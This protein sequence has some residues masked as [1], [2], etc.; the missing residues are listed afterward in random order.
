MGS[1]MAKRWQ[2]AGYQVVAY[3]RTAAKAEELASQG[4]VTAV[5]TVAELV[6]ALSAP[7]IVYVMVPAGQAI[8][9][10]LFGPEG[11]ADQ[12][13]A[14]DIVVDAGNSNYLDT[15]RRSKQLA[16]RQIMLVDQGTSGGVLG[17]TAGYCVMIGGEAE[18]VQRV[19]PL[20]RAIAMED[21]YIHAGPVGAG[22]YVKMIHNGIEYGAMQAMAEG[23]NL[24][25]Q[26][27]YDIDLNA[28]AKTWQH[29][30][31]LESLLLEVLQIQLAEHGQLEHVSSSVSDSGEGQWTVE[32]GMRRAV[33]LPAITA[34]LFARY[35]SRDQDEFASRVLSAMRLGFGGH[36]S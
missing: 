29:G 32:E 34:A 22:H 19:E 24:L 28:L 5:H 31:I 8:E 10:M 27:P 6:G 11:L 25:H 12:L 4:V 33:P 1:G 21:G 36:K 23:F 3:N 20:A 18:A 15:I 35:T 30:S 9:D 26:G 17:A 2:M 14:G 13:A 7:R 16:A